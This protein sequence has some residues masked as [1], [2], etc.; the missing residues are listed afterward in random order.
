V[1]P[2]EVVEVYCPGHETHVLSVDDTLDG[3]DVLPGF[4]LPL[5]RILP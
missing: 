3:A 5:N 1:L 4:K 2:G